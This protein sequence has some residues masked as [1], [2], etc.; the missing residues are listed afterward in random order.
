MGK[1]KSVE[2]Q[3]LAEMIKPLLPASL[4][5]IAIELNI[6]RKTAAYVVRHFI[7]M[8]HLS[9]EKPEVKGTF[10]GQSPDDTFI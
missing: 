5:E 10:W 6:D 8:E 7:G 2:Y 4:D 1:Q 9:K 3:A